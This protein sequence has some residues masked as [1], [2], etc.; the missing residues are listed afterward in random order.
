MNRCAETG[1]AMIFRAHPHSASVPDSYCMFGG[2]PEIRAYLHIPVSGETPP[3]FNKIDC[4][5]A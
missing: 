2:L 5:M 1:K 4:L 3:Q